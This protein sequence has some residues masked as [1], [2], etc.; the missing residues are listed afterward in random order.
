MNDN[1]EYNVYIDESGDE[2]IHKGSKYFILTAIVVPK[3]KDLEISKEVDKIKE[4]LEL[5]IKSQLHWNKIKGFPNKQMIMKRIEN[6]DV[7]IIN[8]IVDTNNI[9]FIPSIEIYNYFSGYLF[10]RI[11]WM[12]KGNAAIANIKISSRGNLKKESLINFLQDKNNKKFKIDYSLIND[13]KIYPNS[14][15]K[16]LQLADCCCSALGQ[17]LKYDDETHKRYISYLKNKFYNY[18]GNYLGYGIKCVP[19]TKLLPKEVS[20]LIYYLK[21]IKNE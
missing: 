13:I 14:S 9:K 10:E 20:D 11:C 2:G 5:N 6:L 1:E 12:M 4:D 21:T 18:K 16:L 8:I 19:G 17:A 3:N 15:K 7:A